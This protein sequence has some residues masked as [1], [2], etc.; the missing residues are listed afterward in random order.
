MDEMSFEEALLRLEEIVGQ[1]E[2]GELSL[3]E[4]LTCFQEGIGLLKFC[5]TRLNVFQE[6]IEVLLNE[7]YQQAPEW[8]IKPDN[9]GGK[10]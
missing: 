6:Q 8:L 3:E 5:A 1:L 4:A 10:K 7:F 2:Q 9:S